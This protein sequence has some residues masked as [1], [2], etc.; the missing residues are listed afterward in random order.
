MPWEWLKSGTG[1]GLMLMVLEARMGTNTVIHHDV[2][3]FGVSRRDN[4]PSPAELTIS[5]NSGYNECS[6]G[7]MIGRRRGPL[8]T[9]LS[10]LS[11]GGWECNNYGAVFSLSLFIV[12]PHAG[13]VPGALIGR[14]QGTEVNT[15]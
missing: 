9:T 11:L 7:C 5:N 13:G 10:L 6:L 2:P 8:V 12:V 1:P 4:T 14:A 3:R 15:H